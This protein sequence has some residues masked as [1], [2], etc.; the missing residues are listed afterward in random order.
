MSMRL[1]WDLKFSTEII[2][3]RVIIV[4]KTFGLE[5][6]KLLKVLEVG[7]NFPGNLDR[8]IYSFGGGTYSLGIKL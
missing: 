2:N 8:Y 1:I 5:V 3:L 4:I 7:G 6:V